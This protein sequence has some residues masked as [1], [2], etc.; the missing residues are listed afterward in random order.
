MKEIPYRHV[1]L[2]TDMKGKRFDKLGARARA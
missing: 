1:D 2:S